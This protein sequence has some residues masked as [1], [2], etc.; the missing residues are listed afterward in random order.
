[1][2]ERLFA[3]RGILARDLARKTLRVALD[4]RQ[5]L[6]RFGRA[7]G[8]FLLQSEKGIVELLDQNIARCHTQWPLG[9]LTDHALHEIAPF[10]IGRIAAKRLKIMSLTQK[11]RQ[12]LDRIRIGANGALRRGGRGEFLGG[13]WQAVGDGAIG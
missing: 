2:R 1:M 12:C 7:M 10:E 5:L 3:N 11:P 13:R 4:L 6:A 8:P 9:L